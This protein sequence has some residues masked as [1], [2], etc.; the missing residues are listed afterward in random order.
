MLTDLVLLSS[1]SF[2]KTIYMRVSTKSLP[3]D[4]KCPPPVEDCQSSQ[5]TLVKLVVFF[6]SFFL[7]G[8]VVVFYSSDIKLHIFPLSSPQV[9][10]IVGQA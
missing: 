5:V 6:P 1:F 8:K 10:K 9:L 4:A 2:T 3:N 7:H